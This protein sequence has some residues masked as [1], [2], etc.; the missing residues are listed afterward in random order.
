MKYSIS[1]SNS[2]IP[3]AAEVIDGLTCEEDAK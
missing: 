2:C 3:T 1:N